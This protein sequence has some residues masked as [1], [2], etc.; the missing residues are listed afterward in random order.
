MFVVLI[1]LHSGHLKYTICLVTSGRVMMNLFLR[2]L[3]DSIMN[4][5]WQRLQ[6]NFLSRSPTFAPVFGTGLLALGVLGFSAIRVSF[7]QVGNVFVHV[8][9]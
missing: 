2:Y 6:V 5:H 1:A 3:K 9:Q 8:F 7:V 4:L